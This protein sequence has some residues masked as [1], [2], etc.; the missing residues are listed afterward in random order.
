LCAETIRRNIPEK[1]AETLAET[2]LAPTSR[3]IGRSP[4]GS[5]PTLRPAHNADRCRV[6]KPAYAWSLR[7]DVNFTAEAPSEGCSRGCSSVLLKSLPSSTEHVVC[8][9][10]P[11]DPLQFE[12]PHWLE[13]HGISTATSTRGL[14]RIYPG[15][16]SSRESAAPHWAADSPSCLPTAARSSRNPSTWRRWSYKGGNV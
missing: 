1:F 12:L 6:R 13:P 7:R 2:K 11:P 8:R 14:I 3:R 5:N 10:G 15:F 4:A 16:A 9:Q